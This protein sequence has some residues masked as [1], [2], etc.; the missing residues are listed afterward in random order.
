ML[1]EKE[2]SLVIFPGA[3]FTVQ[4]AASAKDDQNFVRK[5][6]SLFVCQGGR[7]SNNK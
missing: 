6:Q 2:R 1:K 5:R 3:K 7:E 4:A